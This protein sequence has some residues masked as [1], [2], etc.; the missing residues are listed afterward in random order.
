MKPGLEVQYTSSGQAAGAIA[1][2]APRVPILSS[3]GAGWVFLFT[4]LWRMLPRIW[5]P[6]ALLV[7]LELIYKSIA[8]HSPLGDVVYMSATFLLYALILSVAYR[9][10]LGEKL[11]PLLAVLRLGGDELRLFAATLVFSIITILML[12][13]AALVGQTVG[14]YFMESG[15]FIQ[16]A[17][18]KGAQEV[19]W[20]HDIG[21]INNASV[22][23]AV[24]L[25]ACVLLWFSVRYSL[26]SA[27]AIAVRRLA[28]FEAM[29]IT[30]HNAW[31]MFLLLLLVGASFAFVGVAVFALFQMSSFDFVAEIK[32]PSLGGGSGGTGAGNQMFNPKVKDTA[33]ELPGWVGTA[34]QTGAMLALNLV[35][36]GALA[37]AYQHMTGRARSA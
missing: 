26:V 33:F 6:L 25:A 1:D 19:Q 37:N 28:V 27:H 24:S 23:V 32:A 9:I 36:V 18:S 5:V 11:R 22:L 16:Q 17:A 31:R 34:L 20:L 2:R 7:G 3:L 10:A 15:I 4:S 29:A 13:G 14:A 12:A 21:N 30:K 35:L 8:I